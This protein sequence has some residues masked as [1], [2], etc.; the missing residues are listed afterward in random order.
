MFNSSRIQLLLIKAP[1]VLELQ[2]RTYN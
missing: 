1:F 2:L